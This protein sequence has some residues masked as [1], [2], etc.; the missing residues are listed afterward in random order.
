MHLPILSLENLNNNNNIFYNQDNITRNL[1]NIN[2]IFYFPANVTTNLNNKNHI[3]YLQNNVIIYLNNNNYI[4]YFH[5]SVYE[6]IRN[7]NDL[8][9]KS[10]SINILLKIST[11]FTTIRK[12]QIIYNLCIT[13]LNCVI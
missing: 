10:L 2:H 12:V 6:F 5:A 13:F 3:F 7:K 4:F 1:N 9:K 11:F 8:N